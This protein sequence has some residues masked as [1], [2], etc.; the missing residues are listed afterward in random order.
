VDRPSLESED[1]HLVRPPR[2]G[3]ISIEEPMITVELVIA[4]QQ[5]QL[6]EVYA[7]LAFLGCSIVQPRTSC[8]RCGSFLVT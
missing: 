6:S 8:P 1:G 7:M 4:D 5:G 3:N 2:S